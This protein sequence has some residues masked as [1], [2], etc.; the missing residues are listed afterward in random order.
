M[1][2]DN[3]TNSVTPPSAFRLMRIAALFLIHTCAMSG[4]V[5][6]TTVTRPRQ[7]SC[8]LSGSS[9]SN[10]CK[11]QPRSGNISLGKSMAMMMMVMTRLV[12]LAVNL[13]KSFAALDTVVCGLCSAHPWC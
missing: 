6:T 5:V 12:V 10:H 13:L 11:I 2:A 7:I 9:S 8:A 3:M 4:S 1:H